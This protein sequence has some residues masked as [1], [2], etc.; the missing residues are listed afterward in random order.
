MRQFSIGKSFKAK[1]LLQMI[2]ITQN[3][4]YNDLVSTLASERA[5]SHYHTHVPFEMC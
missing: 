3:F 1:S 2:C 4:N 5:S